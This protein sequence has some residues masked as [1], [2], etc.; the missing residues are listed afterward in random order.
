MNY[1]PIDGKV[2]RR[3]CNKMLPIP[4]VVDVFHARASLAAHDHLFDKIQI[5]WLGND[6]NAGNGAAV[7]ANTCRFNFNAV[8]V[9]HDGVQ[10]ARR[11]V[12]RIIE[13]SVY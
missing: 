4:A 8:V 13:L 10:Y 6:R 2:N 11:V 1:R 12:Q 7:S 9:G 3:K 5:Q